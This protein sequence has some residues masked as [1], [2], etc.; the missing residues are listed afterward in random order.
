MSKTILAL[1]TILLFSCL[2]ISAQDTETVCLPKKVVRKVARDLENYDV[3]K[4]EVRNLDSQL[5]AYNTAVQLRDSAI[6]SYQQ[7]E[8]AL[9][10]LRR[11]EKHNYQSHVRSLRLQRNLSILGVIVTV[12]LSL[13][14]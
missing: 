4:T 5:A 2:T 10:E 7:R 3:C 8:A 13:A 6:Q 12:A 1:L 14:L 11:I 9:D